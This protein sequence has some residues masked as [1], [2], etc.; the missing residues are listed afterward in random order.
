[1]GGTGLQSPCNNVAMNPTV[2]A[3][4]GAGLHYPLPPRT[5]IQKLMQVLSN[6][7]QHVCKQAQ[8]GVLR[9]ELLATE[10]QGLEKVEQ[11][12]PHQ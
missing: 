6:D 1:M 3:N 10:T 9:P 7:F 2:Q 4:R 11:H 8:V 12:S 5:M